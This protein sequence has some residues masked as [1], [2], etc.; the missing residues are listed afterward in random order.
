MFLKISQNSQSA[1]SKNFSQE[2]PRIL[3][4][5]IWK[6]KQIFWMIYFPEMDFIEKHRKKIINLT[7][8]YVLSIPIIKTTQKKRNKNITLYI[9]NWI[10]NLK[11]KFEFRVVF[12]TG[13]NLK[14]ISSKTQE[15]L[16]TNSHPGMYQINRIPTRKYV[17]WLVVFWSKWTYDEMLRLFRT[18]PQKVNP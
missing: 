16:I 11:Q 12:Q 4:K 14:N 3:L 9:W 1:Y 18:P 15:K 17:R 5:I 13:P 8:K 2:L 7:G 6:T 10:K